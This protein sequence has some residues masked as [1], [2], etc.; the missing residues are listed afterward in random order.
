MPSSRDSIDRG[1][2][3][4][5]SRDDD[6]MFSEFFALLNNV[7]AFVT[8]L[9]RRFLSPP[10]P[11]PPPSWSSLVR[12]PKRL[13]PENFLSRT[14]SSAVAC[15]GGACTVD[16][17]D[18][19]MLLSAAEEE[20]EVLS[21]DGGLELLNILFNKPPWLEKLSRLFPASL[22]DFPGRASYS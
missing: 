5:V 12:L 19:S 10:P 17:G 18:D 2:T 7:A 21:F 13:A 4:G 1:M 15:C 6:D 11:P 22:T 8:V 3:F 20:E 16:D 9:L 14:G